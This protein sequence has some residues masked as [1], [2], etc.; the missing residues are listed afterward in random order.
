MIYHIYWGTSG[1][2][3][4]YLD[5]IYQ[6]LKKEGYRQR[7]F[8]NYYY[9]FDYGDKVFFKRSDV[10][11]SK[12]K[13]FIRK[14]FQLLEAWKGFFIILYCSIKDKPKVI[15]Y[16]HAC[17][18][19]LFIILFLKFLKLVSGAKLIITC[20]DIRPNTVGDGDIKNRSTIFR[21]GDYLLVH[22]DNS[23]KE[24]NEYFG[25]DKAHIVK[26]LFPIMDLSKLTDDDKPAQKDTD[27]LFIGHLRKNKG[28]EFLLDSW[29]CFYAKNKEAKL[30]ICGQKSVDS[31]LNERELSKYNI[32]FDLRFIDD[33]EYY[34]YIKNARYVVLPYLFGTNSGIVSTVLS[35][36]T[37]IITSDIPMF[38]EN[39]L[40]PVDC[41]FKN[42]DKLSLIEILQNKWAD[43]N[44][45]VTNQLQ[46]YR[47]QFRKELLNVYNP[48]L[49][50]DK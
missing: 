49:A 13:G 28:V 12:Y 4:L 20:H 37:G 16:S 36:G 22:N 35:L 46:D 50:A 24:L 48:L 43:K 27:F 15:N 23:A 14:V 47:E 26:H 29:K 6:V 9:P 44:D 3:G 18:S 32:E 1:N 2:A 42:G 5:E 31:D 10:A 21:L 38:A 8:V 40:I 11:N 34:H 7:C 19:Y 17:R 30:R 33:N 41:M 39:P 45:H 25:I